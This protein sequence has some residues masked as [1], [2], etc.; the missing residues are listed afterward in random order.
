MC[1]QLWNLMM[2]SPHGQ[3]HRSRLHFKNIATGLLFLLYDGFPPYM[4]RDPF[5]CK[6]LVKRANL[7][8]L[9]G[10]VYTRKKV[11]EAQKQ[12]KQCLFSLTPPKGQGA[13]PKQLLLNPETFID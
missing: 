11:T 1:V 4:Q 2:Q 12:I 5:V 10:N 6:Y 3:M 9:K 7:A 13:F 8:Q